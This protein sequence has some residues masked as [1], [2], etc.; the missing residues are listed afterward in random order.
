MACRLRRDGFLTAEE[1]RP[2]FHTLHPTEAEYADL[3]VTPLEKVL[4][5]PITDL[6]VAFCDFFGTQAAHGLH[7]VGHTTTCCAL[8]SVAAVKQLSSDAAF[9]GFCGAGQ[10]HDPQR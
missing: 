5:T 1:L 3:Q 10:P 4:C 6:A 9:P 7:A 2:V 8:R